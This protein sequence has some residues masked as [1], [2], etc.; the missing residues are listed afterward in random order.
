MKGCIRHA[1]MEFASNNKIDKAAEYMGT[2]VDPNV[3]TRPSKT[4]EASLPVAQM[5]CYTDDG[6][7][8]SKWPNQ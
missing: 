8:N 3:K 1:S 6:A 2:H 7:V 5:A 4:H